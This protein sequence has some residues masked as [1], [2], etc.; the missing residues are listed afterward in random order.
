MA[1]EKLLRA[2][3]RD[4]QAKAEAVIEQAR[5]EAARI[6]ARARERI[7]RRR[8]DQLAAYRLEIGA[9]GEKELSH[10]RQAVQK[11]LLLAEHRLL[12]RVFAAAAERVDAL[13][14]SPAFRDRLPAA[15]AA[16]LDYL[17]GEPM[18]IRCSPPLVEAVQAAV[19]GRAQC[20]VTA[21]E[22]IGAGFVAST[23][24]GIVE[25]D[26]TLAGRLEQLRPVLSIEVLGRM[27]GTA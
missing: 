25:V 8:A 12:G 7:A 4:G 26:G 24:D 2:L 19:A 11:E 6:Q 9:L 22:Q 13:A 23:S 18:R 21:D 20:E 10:A 1:L 16:A 15:V 3:E 17:E 5:A 27:R 14:E